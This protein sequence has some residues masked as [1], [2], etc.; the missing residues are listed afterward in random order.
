MD[1]FSSRLLVSTAVKSS[2]WRKTASTSSQKQLQITKY[3][4]H[5]WETLHINTI[6]GKTSQFSL[7]NTYG[8]LKTDE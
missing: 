4:M 3:S 7:Q 6:C 8:G 5:T 1:L 2:V